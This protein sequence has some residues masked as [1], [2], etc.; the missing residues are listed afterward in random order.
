MRRSKATSVSQL[1]DRPSQ[2]RRQEEN[3]SKYI[4]RVFD[5][6]NTVDE[7]AKALRALDADGSARR[8]DLGPAGTGWPVS[9]W[10]SAD[11]QTLDQDSGGGDYVTD[12]SENRIR[13]RKSFVLAMT[14]AY[15]IAFLAMISGFFEAL[16]MA[17]ILSGIAM[18]KPS[19]CP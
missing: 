9:R 6:E 19:C 4:V 11:T 13:F 14:I 7:G 2:F 17:A 18:K 16:L 1:A 5:D 3:T 8:I 10:P 12:S 15:A